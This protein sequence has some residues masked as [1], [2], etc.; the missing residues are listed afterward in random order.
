LGYYIYYPYT[1]YVDQLYI[2]AG[3]R[4]KI[5]EHLWV[6]ATVRAHGANA[7]AVEFSLGYR[8]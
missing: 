4:R 1:E 8:L 3:L 2:R 5:S 7:E 6:S